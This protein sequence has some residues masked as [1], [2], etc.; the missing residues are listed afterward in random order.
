MINFLSLNLPRKVSLLISIASPKLKENKLI[1]H[2]LQ[3]RLNSCST[4]EKQKEQLSNRQIALSEL[5]ESPD[6]YRQIIVLLSLP[7]IGDAVSQPLS[8]DVIWKSHVADG[9]TNEMI[10]MPTAVFR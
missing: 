9:N 3:R 5:N 10:V 1:T 4:K 6:C 7:S 2:L 8:E